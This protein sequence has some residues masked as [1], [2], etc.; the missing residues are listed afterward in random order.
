MSRRQKNIEK[1]K[2]WRA[3]QREDPEKLE[4]QRQYERDKYQ[5]KKL[6][7]KI[8]SVAELNTFEKKILQEKWRDSKRKQRSKEKVN[9]TCQSKT[10]LNN[11]V[12]LH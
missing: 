6:Q 2:K 8:R 3:K 12:F 11:V 4:R 7:G 5:L 10:Q 1:L 9:N